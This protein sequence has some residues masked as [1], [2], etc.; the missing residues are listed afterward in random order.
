MWTRETW[1]DGRRPGRVFRYLASSV[2]CFSG[3]TF[4][5]SSVVPAGYFDM[6]ECTPGCRRSVAQLNLPGAVA[7]I[8][9]CVFSNRS[10]TVLPFQALKKSGPASAGIGPEPSRLSPWQAAHCS[11]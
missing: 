6:L 8:D 11:L 2:I 10:A 4:A 3:S 9:V 7:G 5:S 1:R